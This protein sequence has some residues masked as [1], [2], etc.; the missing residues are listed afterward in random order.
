MADLPARPDCFRE[1]LKEFHCSQLQARWS[2]DSSIRVNQNCANF[3]LAQKHYAE[4]IR[5]PAV[6]V[7]TSPQERV[8][9]DGTAS[10]MSE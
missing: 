1:H 9:G 4:C 3:M 10:G 7:D 2:L 5:H 6:A 8:A